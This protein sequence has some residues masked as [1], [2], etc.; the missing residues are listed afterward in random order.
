MV[1]WSLS[2]Q[3]IKL[4]ITNYYM[5]LVATIENTILLYFFTW[6]L[7]GALPL[8]NIKTFQSIKHSRV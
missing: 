4:H 3:L 8:N 2:G 6:E 5:Q 7:I 1:Y